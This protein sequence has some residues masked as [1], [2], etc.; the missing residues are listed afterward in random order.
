MLMHLNVV[1]YE[2]FDEIEGVVNT[3]GLGWRR[4]G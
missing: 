2:A 1:K 4:I 3:G